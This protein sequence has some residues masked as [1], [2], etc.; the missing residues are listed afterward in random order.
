MLTAKQI[1]DI[2]ALFGI[3]AVGCA[4]G[5]EAPHMRSTSVADFMALVESSHDD[6]ECSSAADCCPPWLADVLET[7]PK[8]EPQ[9]GTS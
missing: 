7:P 1:K 9:K 2:E 4:K 8:V 5:A 3:D 6:H